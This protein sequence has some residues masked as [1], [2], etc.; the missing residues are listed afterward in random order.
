MSLLLP[1]RGLSETAEQYLDRLV[2]AL[3][4]G[5]STAV[6]TIIRETLPPDTAEAVQ[7]AAGTVTDEFG[8][9]IFDAHGIYVYDLANNL[10]ISPTAV[11]ID[12]AHLVDAAIETAK[13][14]DS[15]INETK[16]AVGAITANKAVIADAAILSAMIGNAQIVDAH[17][18][19]VRANKIAT[20][21][22]TVGT[23]IYVGEANLMLDADDRI[24]VVNDGTRDRVRLG[25]LAVGSYGL[26][27][28]GTDGTEI[29]A[30]NGN[31]LANSLKITGVIGTTPASNVVNWASDP[32]ARINAN[33]VKIDPG[34][35]LISGNTNLSD[36]SAGA[37]ATK[38]AGGQIYTRSIL[39]SAIA[40]NSITASE[41]AANAI[42]TAALA[43]NSVTAD[44]I[45]SG[46]ITTDKLDAASVT[47]LKIAA[48]A[49]TTDAL[50]AGSVTALKVATGTLTAN[51]IAVGSLT[52]D[53]LAANTI[54]AGKMAA[55]SVTTAVLA[56]DAVT[57]GKILAGEIGTGHLAANAVTAAK[58]A[59]GQIQTSH[60]AADAVTATKILAGSIGT[61]HLTADAVTSAKIA[62]GQIQTGHLAANLITADK[63]AAGQI[64]SGH[65]T[66]GSITGAIIQA[67]TLDASKIGANS[68]TSNQIAAN[69]I[70]ANRIQAGTLDVNMI[71]S[72]D[73]NTV[74]LV[75][76]GGSL[77]VWDSNNNRHR[78]WIGHRPGIDFGVWI[79]AADG[80][81]ILAPSGV[82]GLRI[83]D[84][85][86]GTLKLQNE[87]VIV[88][89][90]SST[91]TARTGVGGLVE[92]TRFT[93]DLAQPGRL[94]MMASLSQSFPSGNRNWQ[95]RAQ[96]YFP[97]GQSYFVDRFGG[98]WNDAVALS[99]DVAVGAGS[100]TCVLYWMGQDATVKFNQGHLCVFGAMR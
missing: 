34:R 91:T 63:I 16:L 71:N 42:T 55:G 81:E 15:A 78:A 84:L 93:L 100:Y 56:A 53:R 74:N 61:G 89:R 14:A 65:F 4:R 32:A 95:V 6:S 92:V 35:I 96:I 60:L 47:A 62:A 12:T 39:A 66:A 83:Q 43:A 23:K 33:T 24:I 87:A 27:L 10:I 28:I 59:A 54:T 44:K 22:L 99:G 13:I 38:I 2:P 77:Q 85:T 67:G 51:E 36:W 68:I 98:A 1:V 3:S 64:V 97:N 29:I 46:S 45:V 7:G 75:T 70:H 20:G 76:K 58:I 11:Q 80:S 57:A 41:I 9:T 88:P 82:N 31:V 8:R 72:G 48:G 21:T 25:R 5:V 73:I 37:D 90:S 40:A 30:A 18:D 50:A 26:Q 79:W 52:G 49:I 17:I 19:T 86:V 69:S 94:I